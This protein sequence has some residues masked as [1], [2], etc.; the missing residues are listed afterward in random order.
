MSTEPTRRRGDPLELAS[1]GLLGLALLGGIVWALI[2]G[3]LR[4]AG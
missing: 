1:R 2:D 4:L 3:G